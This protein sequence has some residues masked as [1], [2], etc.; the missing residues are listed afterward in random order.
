MLGAMRQGTD[1][2]TVRVILVIFVAALAALVI[3][4]SLREIPRK[5]EHR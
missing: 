4:S 1:Y 2:A 5:G 3:H